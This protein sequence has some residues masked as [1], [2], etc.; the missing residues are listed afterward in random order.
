MLNEKKIRLM[1]KLALYEK[2]EF[3]KEVRINRLDRSDYISL[4]MIYTA[5]LATISYV[6][7]LSI[8][9]IYKIDFFVKNIN[10]I[11]YI[12]IGIILF[13]FYIIFLIFYLF[14]ARR[15]FSKRYK[16]MSDN[17]ENYN[18]NLRKLH[19][20]YRI[21]SKMKEEK[22]IEIGEENNDNVEI[23]ND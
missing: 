5:I 14:V 22:E 17:M 21:E 6:L 7:M 9:V 19:K 13:I 2:D 3:N 16:T 23:F 12:G 18:D 8:W 10:N 1:T 11:N 4:R 20:M 15:F